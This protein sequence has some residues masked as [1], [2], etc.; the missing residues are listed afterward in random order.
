MSKR[1]SKSFNWDGKE[2]KY[3]FI[4]D[5]EADRHF[6]IVD[7]KVLDIWAADA[8]VPLLEHL[9]KKEEAHNDN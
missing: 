2:Y 3:G 7:D 6:L 9:I 5:G 1:W 8:L 4:E